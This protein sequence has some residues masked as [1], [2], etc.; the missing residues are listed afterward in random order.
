MWSSAINHVEHNLPTLSGSKYMHATV[1]GIM[2][3]ISHASIVIVHSIL[4]YSM[5]GGSHEIHDVQEAQ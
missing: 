5:L 2:E 4:T 3:S 1:E